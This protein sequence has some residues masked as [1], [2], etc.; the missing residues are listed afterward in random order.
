MPPDVK[1]VVAETLEA[2]TASAAAARYFIVIVVTPK[3]TDPADVV[4]YDG[5]DS[6]YG[7]KATAADRRGE[8]VARRT[9]RSAA[10]WC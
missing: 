9:L 7:C 10:G 2:Q 5:E 4:P 6:P 1:I 8:A 3:H